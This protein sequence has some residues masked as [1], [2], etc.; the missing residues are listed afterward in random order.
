M[1]TENSRDYTAEALEVSM[2]MEHLQNY[3]WQCVPE[4]GLDSKY[5]V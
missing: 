2:L 1:K 4:A 5:G 3:A